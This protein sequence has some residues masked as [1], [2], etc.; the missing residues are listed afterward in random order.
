MLAIEKVYKILNYYPDA[1][2]SKSMV[3]IEGIYKVRY[4]KHWCELRGLVSL[5]LVVLLASTL[6]SRSIFNGLLFLIATLSLPVF[7]KQELKAFASN[8][9]FFLL[10]LVGISL[11]AVV[12]FLANSSPEFNLSYFKKLDVPSKFILLLPVL[13]VLDRVKLS[14][15]T[16]LIGFFLGS[17]F[18]GSVAIH[19]VFFKQY[20]LAV[21]DA[22][23]HIVFGSISAIF[24]IGS[25]LLCSQKQ[26]RFKFMGGA[27]FIFGLSAV[28]LSGSR[29]AWLGLSAMMIF[30]L[31]HYIRANKVIF[32]VMIGVIFFAAILVSCYQPMQTQIVERFA[33]GVSDVRNY[34]MDGQSSSSFGDRLS[35][36]KV[37][38]K[39]GLENPILGS[40]PRSFNGLIKHYQAEG[41][42]HPLPGHYKHAH[43]DFLNFFA[44][45][46]IFGLI[47]LVSLYF[48]L[49]K[50]Y[51]FH[52]QKQSKV[53]VWP[54]FGIV[55]IGAYF[56]FGITESMLDRNF[57]VIFFVIT[58][59]LIIS[60][61]MMVAQHTTEPDKTVLDELEIDKANM[62][63]VTA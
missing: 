29:G 18:A 58:Q 42:I 49:L 63:T 43:N 35:M 52:Y 54:V 32:F 36:W 21:G 2:R 57:S 30:F 46:G 38:V 47:M 59:Q 17:I 15:L 13:F 7:K 1:Q 8:Y 4:F 14:Q 33:L 28:L 23:H 3:F 48:L 37:A 20:V 16:I 60:Q 27:G 55:F 26:T 61:I 19:Q 44:A 50:F 62:G 25:L 41:F 31:M 6:V 51:F 56:V 24:A 40:G 10:P 5:L 45:Q 9:S 22:G 39:A 53:N 12:S 11:S 34:L